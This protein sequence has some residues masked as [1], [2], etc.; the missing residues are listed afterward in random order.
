MTRLTIAVKGARRVG[1]I[2]RSRGAFTARL[3]RMLVM[4]DM[5]RASDRGLVPAVGRRPSPCELKR[6]H[7]QKQDDHPVAHC[8]KF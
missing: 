2:D 8:C 4:T 7:D 3:M 1:V 6:Y 5:S